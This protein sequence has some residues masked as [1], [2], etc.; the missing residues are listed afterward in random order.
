MCCFVIM[1]IGEF[2]VVCVIG[3]MICVGLDKK[4]R[5]FCYGSWLYSNIM[6]VWWMG[7]KIFGKGIYFEVFYVYVSVVEFEK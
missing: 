5:G 7:Y 4:F 1:G 2:G 3:L 6:F